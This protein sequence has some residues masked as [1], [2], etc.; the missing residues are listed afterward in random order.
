MLDLGV[1]AVGYLRQENGV[2]ALSVEILPITRVLILVLARS[3]IFLARQIVL[4][5]PIGLEYLPLYFA[6]NEVSI[7]HAVLCLVLLWIVGSRADSIHSQPCIGIIREF[8]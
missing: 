1:L 3:R 2:Q 4:P 7:L 8:L 5:C 6:G